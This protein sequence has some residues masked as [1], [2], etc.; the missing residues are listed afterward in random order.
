[1]TDNNKSLRQIIDFRKDKLKKL[2]AMG[3]VTG[4]LLPLFL[5]PF[6]EKYVAK[7]EHH[8]VV[9]DHSDVEKDLEQH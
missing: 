5:I 7:S 3:I 2:E 9:G 1:M 4:G 8:I 6:L